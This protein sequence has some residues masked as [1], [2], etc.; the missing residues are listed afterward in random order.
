MDSSIF[1][2]CVFLIFTQFLNSVPAS[3]SSYYSSPVDSYTHQIFS[4]QGSS[5]RHSLSKVPSASLASC[6]A[7]HRAPANRVP[8]CPLP[9]Q[10]QR[11]TTGHLTAVERLKLRRLQHSQQSK[12]RGDLPPKQA[13]PLCSVPFCVCVCARADCV[14]A[15]QQI[16]P[17]QPLQ[18]LS[19]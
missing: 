12:R 10:H 2:A 17:R 1:V 14:P 5:P 8:T 7:F 3:C 15:L 18:N 13:P 11:P 16:R 6:P 19:P 9:T 4:A